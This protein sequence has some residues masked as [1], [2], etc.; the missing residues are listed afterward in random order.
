MDYPTAIDG[1]IYKISCKDTNIKE[2][3]IGG[4]TNFKAR[5]YRHKA[6]CNT[7][8][9]TFKVYQFI[10][11]HGGWDNWEM[12]EI[13]TVKIKN[14]TQLN[15]IERLYMN[16]YTNV[17]N[18]NAPMRTKEESRQ[19]HI[20]YGRK[21]RENFPELA[22]ESR[23]MSYAKHRDEIQK[24]KRENRVYCACCNM[25]FRRDSLSRHNK[26]VTHVR[27]YELASEPKSNVVIPV[28]LSGAT[29]SSCDSLPIPSLPKA[30]APRPSTLPMPAPIT[31]PSGPRALPAIADDATVPASPAAAPPTAPPVTSASEAETS[32]PALIDFNP[33]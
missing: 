11:Q 30:K 13:E 6:N 10:N 8:S 23:R 27:N 7:L 2:V 29:K 18:M 32:S 16:N 19:Y 12:S 3:Y 4:T 9:C 1:T 28:S 31:V 26:S 14:R 24:R 33:L 5:Q 21:Y 15:M 25:T 22:N 20:D 17:L